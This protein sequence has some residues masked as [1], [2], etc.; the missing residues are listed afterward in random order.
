MFLV[1]FLRDINAKVGGDNSNC[2]AVM[3][4]HD[5][6]IKNDNGERLVEYA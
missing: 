4:K 2:E 5:C 6:G 3:R 1:M